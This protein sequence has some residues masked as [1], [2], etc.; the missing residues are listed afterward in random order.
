MTRLSRKQ[1]QAIHSRKNE[2]LR[3]R[4]VARQKE[5]LKEFKSD[6]FMEKPFTVKQT[7]TISQSDLIGM[8]R[9]A[10]VR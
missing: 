1:L 8:Q 7:K 9:A 5:I 3:D 4:T 10:G 2:I 6:E